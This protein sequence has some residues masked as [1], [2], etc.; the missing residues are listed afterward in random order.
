[1]AHLRN[2]FKVVVLVVAYV[3]YVRWVEKR[4]PF[5]LSLP[6]AVKETGFGFLLGTGIISLSV[7]LLAAFGCYQI[8][9]IN[10]DFSLFRY[11]A[12]L[13]AVA[14]LEELIFRA[15]L[16]RLIERS[17][18]S[19]IA[20]IL[21]TATF[22]LV[23]LVNP[24]ATWISAASLALI[25]LIFVG[26]FLLTRRLWLC[27]GLHWSWNLIQAMYSVPISGTETKG[28]FSGRVTGPAWLT[29]GSFGIEASLVT[30]LL[31][32]ITAS[33][34]LYVAHKKGHFISPYWRSRDSSVP[35]MSS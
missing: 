16:F 13:L 20:I 15:V 23:H 26:S 35:A 14:V 32:L 4:S 9:G 31:S 10:T 12:G 18:G 2:A 1:M 25:S 19:V 30:V 11:V 33:Y 24:N 17:L 5:E 3:G 27:V 28:L 8:D 6:G 22:G 21:S 7:A 34:L 29:G